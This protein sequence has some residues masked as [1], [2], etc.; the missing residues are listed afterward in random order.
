MVGTLDEVGFIRVYAELDFNDHFLPIHESNEDVPGFR[1][2]F[3]FHFD[4]LQY[5]RVVEVDPLDLVVQGDDF[6]FF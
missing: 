6:I 5:F 3:I 4:Y 2:Q 1:S